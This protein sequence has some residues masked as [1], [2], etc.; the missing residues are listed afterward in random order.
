[1]QLL[2]PEYNILRRDYWFGQIDSRPLSLFRFCFAALLL[3]NALYLVPLSRRLYSDA[4]IVPRAQ[5][6]DKLPDAYHFSLM[7]WLPDDWMAIV[8]FLTWA[9]VALA[10][11]LGYRT[12]L[13]SL[14]NLVLILS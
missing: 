8:F 1:M 5:F 7:D 13:M 4:G 10:L 2:H 9:A 14:L 6:W 3:K 12:W 11:L